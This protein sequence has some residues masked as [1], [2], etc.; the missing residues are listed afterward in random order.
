MRAVVCRGFEREDQVAVETVEPPVMIADGVRI[1]VMSSG[2][3]FA[4]LLALKGRHQN[5][6]TPPFTPGTEIAGIV[7]E[8]D[9]DAVGLALNL[10]VDD[11][12]PRYTYSTIGLYQ[13]ALFAPPWCTIPAGN[14][15]GIKAPLAPL[16][17]AAMDNGQV[18]AEIY[19]GDWTDAGTPERLQSLNRAHIRTNWN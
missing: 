13:R 6:A 10:S 15:Q 1:K 14:P 17:R 4:N 2:V 9:A 12:R 19:S 16:L 7:I 8:C 5:R 11:P 3:S 18:S